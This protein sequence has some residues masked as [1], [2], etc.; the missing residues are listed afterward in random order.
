MGKRAA[1]VDEGNGRIWQSWETMLEHGEVLSILIDG[2]QCPRSDRPGELLS[3]NTASTHYCSLA[4]I[5]ILSALHSSAT[6]SS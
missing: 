2:H 3:N 6:T 5:T 1:E 4:D